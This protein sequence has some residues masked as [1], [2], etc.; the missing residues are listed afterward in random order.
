[1]FAFTTPTDVHDLLT[2]VDTARHRGVPRDSILEL[3]L[4]DVPPETVSFDPL[5]LV[6]SG[7]S[8]PLSLR[9][10]IAAIHRAIDDP[11]VAGL[12]ARVQIPPAA[13]GA[14]QEL[15]A[16]IEA[17]SAVKPSVAWAETY[18]GTLA[19]YLA[20]AFGEVWMQPSGTVGL[21]GFAANGTF[22]RGALDK[23][24]VEAQF[25]ARG[26]YKSAANLFTED[27]YTE[28]Q[29]E[30]DGRLL[31][32]LSE[33]VRDGV[34]ASRKLEPADV[35]ALTDRAPLR[36]TDA[37]DAGLVDRIGYRDEAYARIAEV[38]GVQAGK[39]PPLLYLARYARAT[40]PQVPGLPALPGRPSRRTIGVVT[41]AG[42]IV[43]GRS[44]PRLFPPGPASGG[45]V[46]AE[47]LRDAVAD[48]SVAAIVLR[49]DSPGGSV[50]GSET[51]WREVIRAREAGKPVV[52][53]MGAVAGSGGY[54]VAMG[55]DAII[56]NPGTITGS[57][58]VITGKFITR[59]LKEKLGVASAT[60]RTNANADAWSSN[61]PF[62]DEQVD[63]VEAEI[64]LHYNDFV[65]R[66]ADGRNL[67][68]DA[69]KA[70]AQGRIWSGRDALEHGLVD[71]LGGFRDAVAKAKE[72]A[73]IDADDDVRIASFPSSPLSSMLRQRA[74]SQPAAAAVTDAVL[75][76]VAQL[77]METVQRAQRS[78]GSAQTMMMGDYRF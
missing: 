51:I 1:M 32:S 21:I 65:Q 60:L 29:R 63:L 37:V 43:S 4:L 76:R 39:E 5:G 26:Q 72:L 3:D 41:L 8:R 54:Y 55:A 35:D 47:A 49:V 58:G 59:G 52:A 40:R 18:P 34:A 45:D 14:V 77:A 70:V 56:A 67:T 6:F 9:H 11:R 24:G 78:I 64:D 74:S 20:S 62:T 30:A 2:K 75:G 12:I 44:G 17:F 27:G 69:V 7:A 46:I 53:S 36:R 73:D 22:L 33:Q 25:L 23:A 61:E 38:T 10:T 19:Y 57:I 42:P 68:V 71:E 50:N 16:A 31:E 28:A 48:D 66:V 13:A 15:R